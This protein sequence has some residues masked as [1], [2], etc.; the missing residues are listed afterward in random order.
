MPPSKSSRPTVKERLVSVFLSRRVITALCGLVGLGLGIVLTGSAPAE[1]FWMA[2]AA[3]ALTG[4]MMPITNGS[5]GAVLQASIAPEMQG[6]VFALI[7]SAATAMAPLGLVIAG[8][9]SDVIG[10]R[11]WFWLAGLTCTGMGLLGFGLPVVLG[12]EARPREA[13]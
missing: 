6:R 4:L 11:A 3:Q 12:F 8:P 9:V 7:L 1:A 5:F 10:V 13:A 2:L